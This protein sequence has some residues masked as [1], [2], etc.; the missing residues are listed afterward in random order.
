MRIAYFSPLRPVASGIADYS[1]ELLPHLARHM[2]IDLFVDGYEPENP[3][4]RECFPIYDAAEFEGRHQKRPYDALLYQMGNHPAHLYIYR[5]LQRY[6]GV[7]VLHDLVLHHFLEGVFLER[8]WDPEAYRAAFPEEVRDSLLRRCLAGHWSEADHFLFSGLRTVLACSQ[9]VIVHS[10][11][12]RKEVLQVLPEARVHVVPLCVGPDRSPFRGRPPAEVKKELGL[13]PETLLLATFGFVTP[14]KRLD[15]V[16]E[17]YRE[18]LRDEPDARYLVVG[19]ISPHFDLRRLVRKLGL[20]GLVWVTGHVSLEDFY[21]LV[22]ATDI[23]IQLRYPSAGET[24][25]ALLRVMSKGKPVLVSNYRQFAEFPDD[26][27]LK[28]DLGPAEGAMVGAYL[29][30]LSRDQELRRRIGERARE[31]IAAHHSV[32]RTVQG[33]LE[34]LSQVSGK[35]PSPGDPGGTGKSEDEMEE[36]IDVP[37][38]VAAIRREL[39]RQME[40]GRLV[41]PDWERYQ[42]VITDG[43]MEEIRLALAERWHAGKLVGPDMG[44]Y[45]VFD[46]PPQELEENLKVLNTR[47]NQIYEP[48]EVKRRTPL[49]GDL[50]ARIRRRFHEEVRSYLDPMIYRQSE[51][52]GAIVSTLNLLARGFYGGSLA[53]SLQTLQREVHELRKQVE[54]LQRHL[55]RGEGEEG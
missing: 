21:G 50:W 23:G 33:Y 6:P 4:I 47:W 15:I 14:G 26:A 19:E 45:H 37:A 13:P 8:Q 54:D 28:V 17:A 5:L 38:L 9:A 34:V 2:D 3:Y 42:T 30:L 48:L 32:E 39:F 22:D 18:L 51:I 43:L 16:L 25:A 49:L 24:S 29:A 41:P 12:A 40:E 46:T 27:C 11:T 53:R 31:Y 52:N 1:E 36:W 7:V 20:E 35:G 55:R 10:E 44:R